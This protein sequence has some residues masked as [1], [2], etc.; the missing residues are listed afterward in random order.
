MEDAEGY[1]SIDIS[2]RTLPLPPKAQDAHSK[3]WKITLGVLL[4]GSIVLNVVLIT[5]LLVFRNGNVEDGS[6]PL[7]SPNSCGWVPGNS[8]DYVTL[9]R[10]TAHRR[11]AISQDQKSVRWG[12]T[13]QNL[14]NDTKR[15]DTRLWVL[16][17]KGFNSGKHCWEA[18]VKGNGE[19][20]VGVAKQ[21]VRRK[22]PT[23]FSTKEGI[24]GVGEYW[25]TGNYMAFT[26]PHHTPLRFDKKPRRIR[27][28]L[29]YTQGLVEF[30]NAETKLSIYTFHPVSFSGEMVYPWFRVWENTE[31][32]LHP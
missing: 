29:D 7:K 10:D 12:D 31:L 26:S 25:G 19:W 23:D 14:P 32:I 15:F 22:G 9:D 6:C 5:L 1:M 24:W 27:V 3:C 16:G 13:E 4:A 2:R 21:S 8:T 11:L 20:A 17:Q 18:E 30:F 28:F